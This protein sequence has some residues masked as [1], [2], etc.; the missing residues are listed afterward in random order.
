MFAYWKSPFGLVDMYNVCVVIGILCSVIVQAIVL[1][2]TKRNYKYL[3]FL[4][5]YFFVL[6]VGKY[7][8]S[9]VRYVNIESFKINKNLIYNIINTNGTHFLGYII[10]YVIFFYPASWFLREVLN[11]FTK[12]DIC[13]NKELFEIGEI[14][15]IGLP[16]QHIFNRLGCLCRGCCYGVKYNGLF[17]ISLQYN[18]NI[19]YKVFPCQLLEI[20]GMIMIIIAIMLMHKKYNIFSIVIIGFALTFLIAEFFTENVG[21]TKILGLTYVQVMSI[22]ICIFGLFVQRMKDTLL[23]RK[24]V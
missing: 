6:Y 16:V 17:A 13:N 3:L 22:F 8:A 24:T 15:S 7:I 9:F 12:I 5:S 10:A 11:E 1:I 2:K 23:R 19:D 20:I 14:L 18:R 21:V 4:I